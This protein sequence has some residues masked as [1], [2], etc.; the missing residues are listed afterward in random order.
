MNIYNNVTLCVS[1]MAVGT[2][3]ELILHPALFK[4]DYENQSFIKIKKV[5]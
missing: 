1:N 2:G 4:E 3:Y 5:S